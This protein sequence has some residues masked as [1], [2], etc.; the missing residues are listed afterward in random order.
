MTQTRL[1]QPQ[2]IIGSHRE[3]VRHWG[4]QLACGHN[5]HVRHDP[6][7]VHR[8]WTQ[9]HN[10][11]AS[12]LGYLLD[13]EKCVEVSASDARQTPTPELNPSET[14]FLSADRIHRP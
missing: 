13:C 7:L 12:M 4:A 5:Q 1:V 14:S 11:G 6:P 10:G 9:T 2:R 3:N 8:P